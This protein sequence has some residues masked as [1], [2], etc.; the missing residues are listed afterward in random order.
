MNSSCC[1]FPKFR[2]SRF[3]VVFSLILATAGAVFFTTR[4][5]TADLNAPGETERYVA[6]VISAL[7]ERD[8]L[9]KQKID[10]EISERAMSTFLRSLDPMKVYFYQKD[11]DRFMR[12]RHELDDAVKQGDLSFAFE[13]FDL[14]LDRVDERITMV[15]ELLNQKF[16]FEKQEEMV[17]DRDAA[18]YP[19]SRDEA[20]DRWRKRIKYDLLVLKSD[21]TTGEEAIDRL[22]RRYH[23]YVKRMHQLESD[24]LMEMFLNAV[25]TGLDPHT[26]Y[27]SPN[28]LN[29]F[30]IQMRL[31]LEG[32]GAVLTTE[33]G[34]TV[35]SKIMPGGAAEEDGRLKP[36]DRIVSVGQAHEGEMVDIVDMSLRDV[37]KLIR[38]KKGTIVRLGV[39]PAGENKLETYEIT[40]AKVELR[41]S[42]AQ[43]EIVADP[44][45]GVTPDGN[46]V[47][48]GYIK[49]PSFYQDTAA[50]RSGLPNFKSTTR[51]VRVI[52]DNF[53][54]QEVEAVLLDL[55]MNGG[56]FLSEAIELTGL[57]IDTGTVVQVK[58]SDSRVHKFPDPVRG[59]S[60]DGPLVVMT[61]KLSASAS[62]ILAGAI[63]DYDRGIVVGDS[64][65]H[66]KGTVQTLMNVGEQL[67]RH[68]KK[69]NL[70]ALKITMQQFYRPNGDSTQKRGVLSDL[71]LP[72]LTDHMDVAESHR[73]YPLKFDKV[74]AAGLE[75]YAGRSKE[76]IDELAIKSEVRRSDSEDFKKLNDNIALYLAQKEKK[77]VT[78]NEE[79]FFKERDEFD[80]RKED[81]KTMKEQDG[82]DDSDDKSVLKHD[83]YIDEVLTITSDYVNALANR[84]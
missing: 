37:V 63:Q 43:G 73:D 69:Q 18:I 48:I 28:S 75:K 5:S 70:G 45:F 1:C 47:K 27:M 56:G 66:G 8:H 35:V 17:T 38:G 3:F 83:F 25:M 36:E 39:K 76:L 44:K 16:D 65:T 40:R 60:W 29:E 84:E 81:E 19:K 71:T 72:S 20:F 15:D 30:N 9:L 77:F 78:L 64:S 41:E 62:E 13:V 21:E 54:E 46:P 24:D 49:L 23:G 61:N 80:A 34:Y 58:D 32:I 53:R 82:D 67:I 59:V 26:A 7:V 42:E 6:Y 10:D 52:L 14:F 12:Q 51:D 79:Q 33:D 31:N 57:F 4:S 22:T 11:V 74:A 2:A 68:D 55:R 50:A